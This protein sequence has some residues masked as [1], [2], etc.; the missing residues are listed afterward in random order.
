MPPKITLTHDTKLN[1]AIG[2]TRWEK[3]WK[4]KEMLW[5]DLVA[6]V[7]HTHYTAETHG[8]YMNAKRDRQDEIKD[9]GGFVGGFLSSGRRKANNVVNR[10]LVTLDIDFANTEFWDDFQ[11]AYTCAAAMYSTHKHEPDKPRLRLIIPLDRAVFADEYQAIA[12]KIAGII[13][14]ELFDPTTFQPERLM[15]WPSTSKDAVYAFEYQDGV[16]LS[17]DKILGLYQDWT[18]SS[19]WPVSVKVDKVIQRGMAKQG[20]PLEKD[21]VVG[22]FCRSHSITEVMEKYLSDVYEACTVEN[23]YTYKEGSTA[24]GLVV[25]DDKFVY[26]HHGT[27]PVSGKLCNAFD[28]VRLHKYGLKDESAAE[29]CPGN[30]LPSYTAMVELAMKDPEV[31]KIITTDQMKK[32]SKDFEFIVDEADD[33][34]GDTK[35]EEPENDEWLKQLDIDRKGH[36]QSSHANIKVILDNDPKLKGR[37]GYDEFR[38]RKVLLRHV[39]WRRITHDTRFLRD[40][41][42]QNLNIYLSNVYGILNRANAKDV[43][44]TTIAANS[45]HSVR[46]YLK[47]LKWDKVHR[48]ETLFVDYMGAADTPYLRAI[49]RKS[50]AACVARVYNPGVKFDYVLTLVGEEGLGKSSVIGKLGREWFSDSFSFNML[51][52]KE[53]Y[54]QIQGVWLIEI[55]ELNGLRRSDVEAVKHFISKREDSFRAA[56]ARN[57]ST[58]KRQCVFFAS[59]NNLKFLREANGN[60]RFWPVE[61]KIQAPTKD[62]FTDLTDYEIQ[63]IWAEAVC[64]YKAGETLFLSKQLEDEARNVQRLH[65]EADDRTGAIMKY[66]ETMVPE[67]WED[68]TLYQRRAFL[69]SDG[70]D[71]TAPE[72]VRLRG[73]ICVAE[74]WCELMGGT[75]KDMTSQNTKPIHTIM[76]EMK[77]WKASKS[78]Q[79]FN[80]FGLQNAYLREENVAEKVKK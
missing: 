73:R 11:L 78:K 19:E 53:A 52:T 49:T 77:G 74:I 10:Q 12:R 8:E 41:D 79:R 23:R 45:F 30:R 15:Y 67:N 57:T 46:D 17:A 25:Y 72:G 64:L 18:D 43:L 28:L 55:G 62:V 76:Q 21:G 59:T 7:S 34:L 5:S 1:I 60:R 13:D 40:E 22:A 65:T 36:I 58:L 66:L 70:E 48:L 51:H 80:G 16:F 68:M 61:I 9:I 24:A 56:Y 69:Q 44:D 2:K 39:P 27:D 50:I 6:K 33:L 75:P 47:D 35:D 31:R 42:E 14:I 26:S 32:A 29:D 4:N 3:N 20:D 38:S 71:I 54:E 37:F 63:Q